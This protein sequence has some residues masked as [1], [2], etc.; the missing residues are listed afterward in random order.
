[1][2]KCVI[3]TVVIELFNR[4]VDI[5]FN[6]CIRRAI[7]ESICRLLYCMWE[8]MSCDMEYVIKTVGDIVYIVIVNVK[9]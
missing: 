8:R 2:L 6:F 7:L 5:S 9:E 4:S 1:M 3:L